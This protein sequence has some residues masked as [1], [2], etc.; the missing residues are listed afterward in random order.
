MNCILIIIV[1]SI[2]S[3]LS[4]RWI[5]F[6]VLKVAKNRGV[7][8][9]PGT[10]KLHKVPIPVMGGMAVFFGILSGVLI[11][12]ALGASYGNN[13]FFQLLPVV[14]AMSVL[15]FIGSLDDLADLN[16]FGRLV[17]EVMA[18]SVLIVSTGCTIDNFEG[19]WSIDVLPYWPSFILTVFASVGIIN[20]INMV[21]GVNGLASSLCIMT[22]LFFGFI[23]LTADCLSDAVLAFCAASSI[24]PF[25]V[26]NLF[27]QSSRMFLGDAGTMPLGL[28]MS[29]FVIRAIGNGCVIEQLSLEGKSMIAFSLAVL[30]LP[31]FDALRVM[32]MR[33]IGGRSPFRPDKTHL[34]H[35]FISMEF[36]HLTTTLC[37][38]VL[39]LLVVAAWSVS[40][41][42][43]A[44][45]D[46]QLYTVVI[47]SAILIWG[48][49]ILLQA[50]WLANSRLVRWLKKRHETT[51]ASKTRFYKTLA[52]I[53]DAPEHRIA[54]RP[55]NED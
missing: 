7:V 47:A 49:S 35:L 42:C 55:K 5:Y 54:S 12:S 19:L 44:G 28:L 2:I 11:G 26:H 1:S 39:N 13:V 10:R 30:S 22:C 45:T 33:A 16:P 8:D 3:L 9:K 6:W 51:N 31:V 15:H 43:G 17:I 23:F 40:V 14:C 52:D 27:G 25:V 37:E 24:L 38:V 32:T 34:H 53:L 4:V 18:V 21:D 41:R 50:E 48:T 36:G 46:G 29:Y 20:A